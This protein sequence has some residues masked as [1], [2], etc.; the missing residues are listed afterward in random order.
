MLG[1]QPYETFQLLIETGGVDRTN[2]LLIAAC[3]AYARRGRPTPPEMEQFE[4]LAGRLF[5]IAGSQAKA[6]GAAILGRAEMLSSALEQLVIDNIGEDL[7]SFLASAK[8]LSEP[9]MLEIIARYDVPAAATIA[10]R[11][12]LSN[13]VLAKLFQMNSRKVYRALASNIAIVPRGAYLSALARSAQMDHMVAE[14]LAQR[15]DFD[16]ALLAPAFF[17]LSD[18]HRI[19]VI[20]SFMQRATPP[21]PIRKTIEQLSVANQELTK[22]LMKLFSENRRPEVTRLLSQITGLDEVR[23]GQIAHDV[24]GAS[25]FVILRAFG[26]TAYDGLKVLIHATSHDNDRSRALADFATMFGNVTP[27]SMA[28]LMSAWRGEVNLLELNKPEYKPFTETSRR[29]PSQLAP[30]HNP[31]VDQA[32]EALARIGARRAG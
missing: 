13:V 26:C 15:S 10:A 31:V 8:E 11:P 17:D 21:A 9:T 25:L 19:K 27:E 24:T 2:T 4:A 22:A 16:A 14:A 12:D 23:C 6:K 32:I 18:D 29:T 3:D 7:I 30:A 28:Y 5:P 20:R 1:F